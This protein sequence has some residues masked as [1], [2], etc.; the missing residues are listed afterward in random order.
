MYYYIYDSF[1][2]DKKH[3]R[4]VAAL[5]T[6]FA[7]L[8]LNGKIGR[9]TPFQ[10]A[11]GLIRDEVKR[12]M[13][14]VVAVGNDDTVAKV[15]EALGDAKVTL[16]IIPVGGPCD[17][18]RALGIPEGLDACDILSKR[19]T[20]TIDLGLVNGR[21]FLSSLRI[22][23]GGACLESISEPNDRGDGKFRV[24]T[25]APDTDI[26]FSNLS[27]TGPTESGGGHCIGDPKD[28]LLDV[29]FETRAGARPGGGLLGM[30][31]RRAVE[32]PGVIPLRS[33]IVTAAEPLTA[34]ADG[35]AFTGASLS[36]EVVPD[37]LRVI[38][39]RGRV[40]AA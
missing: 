20:Q 36:I 19:V 34:V 18:A 27:F 21:Y 10:S 11:R 40:F 13:Q 1:L 15:V 31:S 33:A 14:T 38:T 5:E 24:T 30:F 6:R 7:D 23:A 26:V 37:R 28:G 22:P 2:A 39:G 12:G 29:L 4:L 17:I 9:L 32:T 16:G 3:D 8:G 25:L 35:K